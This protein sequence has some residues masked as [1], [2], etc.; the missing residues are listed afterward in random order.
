MID[1]VKISAETFKF[2]DEF[3]ETRVHWTDAYSVHHWHHKREL[4]EWCV[5]PLPVMQTLGW[6]IYECDEYIVIGQSIGLVEA[7]DL[8]KIPRGMIVEMFELPEKAMQEK[9]KE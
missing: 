6:L 3:K 4:E 9:L 7:A 5:E 2:P 8:I 1:S